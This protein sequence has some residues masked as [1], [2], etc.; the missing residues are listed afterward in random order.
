MDTT[1]RILVTG[2]RYA[3]PEAHRAAIEWALS[4]AKGYPAVTLI[5]GGAPGVDTIA[6]Q[7]ATEWGWALREYRANWDRFGKAAGPL[8]NKEMVDAGADVVT[9]FPIKGLAN[10]GT[11]HCAG[12]ADEQ[13]LTVHTFPLDPLPRT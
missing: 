11:K 6:A 7:I 12:Y 1:Y 9:A 13:G 10:R 5:H 4:A 3:T 8:R 2:S